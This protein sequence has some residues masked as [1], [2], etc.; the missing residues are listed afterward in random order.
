MPHAVVTQR[1]RS[2][3]K[4]LRQTLTRAET[5]RWGYLKAN[6]VDGLGFRRQ[7]PIR[8][9]IADFACLSANLVVELD[10]ETPNFAERQ[11]GD[12]TRDALFVAQGFQ[13]LRF[14]NEH[15]MSNL[16]GVV[17]VIRE[18]ASSRVSGSLPSP[19]LP[20]KA[21]GNREASANRTT[22]SDTRGEP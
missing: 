9:Y 22:S 20:H 6:R 5:R 16:E 2:R 18:A 13:V 1:Q 10:G 15:V 19:T 4:R 11:Q 7:T 3:A 12:Q 8:N 21:G 14:S 17:E